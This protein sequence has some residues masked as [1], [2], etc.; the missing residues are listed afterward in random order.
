MNRRRRLGQHFLASPRVISAIVDAAEISGHDTV[1]EVGTGT[2]ALT[3]GLCQNAKSV[4]SVESDPEL[5]RRA[6][7][8][9]LIPNLELVCADGF[10]TD[11]EF[12]V[13]VSSLPYSKSRTAI[14]WLCQQRF[15][16]AVI[17]TQ[18]EFAE[19]LLAQDR[20]VSVIANHCFW[21]RKILDVGRNSFEPPPGVDSAVLKLTRRNTLSRDTI[22]GVNLMFS[23]RRK[24][25]SNILKRFGIA[26]GSQM[27]LDQLDGGELI[28]LGRQIG[29]R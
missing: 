22:R 5:Y 25:V 12:S 11:C 15:S 10:K 21:M 3:A 16:R 18:K 23:Y 17:V 8:R 9:L 4:I 14:E 13:F 19:K 7:A 1:L 26:C 2:G 6:R 20:S 29:R 28:E 27:R 24:T